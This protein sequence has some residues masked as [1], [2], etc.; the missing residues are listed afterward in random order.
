M[1][2]EQLGFILISKDFLR[3]TLSISNNK[4]K[5]EEIG[6]ELGEI[7]AHE[8]IP[9][10]FPNVNGI[11]LAQFLEIW[12]TRF[13][14]FKHRIEIMTKDDENNDK[15]TIVEVINKDINDTKEEKEENKVLNDYLKRGERKEIHSFALY[16]AINSNFSL[17]LKAMIQALIESTLKSP[18]EFKD[19]SSNSISFS[20][21]FYSSNNNNRNK[22]NSY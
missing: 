13:Q 11:T 21:S 18:V 8:Y 7:I 14:S 12:F 1:Q 2:F 9:Y 15:N 17:A 19:V 6:K 4:K 3:K 16:H 10:L 5:I 20:F 22:D